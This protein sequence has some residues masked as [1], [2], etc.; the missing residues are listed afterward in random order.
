M[1]VPGI[2]IYVGLMCVAAVAGLVLT[3]WSSLIDLTASNQAALVGLAVIALLFESVAIR[4]SVGEK[5]GSASSIVFIPLLAGVQLFG[6]A[7]G[8]ALVTITILF[9]EFVVR[10]KGL[11]QGAFNVAQAIVAATVAGWA[12]TLLGGIPLKSQPGGSITIASQL[13]PF[14]TFG[15]V[16]LALNHAAISLAITLSQ[17]LPFRQVWA[18]MLRHSGGSL[19]DILISPIALAV[20]FLYVQAGIVRILVLLLPMV[21]IRYSYLAASR[22]REANEDLLKALVKAIETRDPYTSG[23]SLRVSHLAGRVAEQ[24]GLSAPVVEQIK[25]AGLLHDIG[26]IEPI[27]MDILR[28]PGSLSDEERAI[29][30]SH[31]TKG[32]ALL[33]DLSSVPESVIKTVRHHH[34]REDG[35]GYPDRLLGDEIPVGAKIIAACD[36]VDAMFSDR[37]YRK[38]LPLGVV[39]EQLAEHAGKQFDH[40]IV[41]AMMAS[42]VLD[43]YADIMRLGRE[44]TEIVAERGP[45]AE[46]PPRPVT[47][48]PKSARWTRYPGPPLR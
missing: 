14:I 43:D 27:F 15:L 42:D 32:V 34:E 13:W 16:I 45:L 8:T 31:V 28:K 18:K 41:R 24:R 47:R 25:M 39:R 20:A 7:T 22:V 9:G 6:P 26:K 29:I 19:N 35:T 46:V 38:A 1:K 36:A 44:A 33:R 21:F 37:P 10:R 11:Q 4:L 30:E 40:R 5:V 17:G 12:F 2:R 23:H 3:P 48:T